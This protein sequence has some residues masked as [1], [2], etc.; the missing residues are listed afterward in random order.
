M[1]RGLTVFSLKKRRTKDCFLFKNITLKN[2]KFGVRD[3]FLPN[4]HYPSCCEMWPSFAEFH[5]QLVSQYHHNIT[6]CKMCHFNAQT[7]LILSNL[8]IESCDTIPHICHFFTL[9]QFEARKFYTQKCLN[10]RQKLICDKT[11]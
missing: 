6:F 4:V 5:K 10:S 7:Y 2:K 3:K 11:A 1:I 8:I 9:T